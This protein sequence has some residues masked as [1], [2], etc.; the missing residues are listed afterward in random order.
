MG[1]EMKESLSQKQARF[2]FTFARFVVWIEEHHAKKHGYIITFGDAFRDPRVH[3]HIGQK[4]AYG[5]PNS[6]HKLKL[7]VDINC[8]KGGKLVADFYPELHDQ[9]DKMGGAER[10]LHDLNH[11]SFEHNGVR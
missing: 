7:A 11:F 4:M 8:I 6:A 2:M 1:Q 9:W 5:H 3:G 10:I